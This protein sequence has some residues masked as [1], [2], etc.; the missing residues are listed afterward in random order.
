MPTAT[1][2]HGNGEQL[3]HQASSAG[4]CERCCCGFRRSPQI[5]PGAGPSS[6]EGGNRTCFVAYLV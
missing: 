1:E 2:V 5:A 4:A 3:L 6:G